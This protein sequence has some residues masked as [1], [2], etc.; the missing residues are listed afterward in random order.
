MHPMVAD[1][2]TLPSTWNV[3]TAMRIGADQAALFR[4]AV[5]SRSHAKGDNRQY[6]CAHRLPT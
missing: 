3:S 4:R 1:P 2:M 5:D 6:G